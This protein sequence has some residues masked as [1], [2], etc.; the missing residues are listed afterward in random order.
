MPCKGGC[1]PVRGQAGEGLGAAGGGCGSAR[2][3]VVTSLTCVASTAGARGPRGAWVPVARRRHV[4]RSRAG[5]SCFCLCSA[6]RRHRRLGCAL[7]G[8]SRGLLSVGRPQG[9]GAAR[10]LCSL[11]PGRGKAAV[12]GQGP[13]VA[14]DLL[15]LLSSAA[16]IRPCSAREA[17]AELRIAFCLFRP[18][19]NS[20]I[21]E[22]G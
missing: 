5:P 13:R 20:E 12:L 7:P 2:V 8:L 19:N 6:A 4:G 17:L 9:P 10:S 21:P 18:E 11:C 1:F 16:L 14:W 15:L 22:K 3:V